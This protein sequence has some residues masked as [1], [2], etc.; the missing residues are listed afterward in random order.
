AVLE[1]LVTSVAR[2]CA[3]DRA[4]VQRVEGDKGVILAATNHDIRVG[5]FPI[6]G[7]VAEDVIVQMRTIHIFGTMD[8]Q[9]ARY[10]ASPAAGLGIGAQ[11][12]TP[13][14][15]EGRPIGVISL[16]R[17]EIRPFSDREIALLETFADQAV[18][19]IEN[20][21]LF[22]ALQEANQQFAEASQ[23]KSNFLANMSH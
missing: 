7:T 15:R 3:A 2:L 23:H 8:E 21:R 1:A 20:A 6:A 14:L 10:R 5:S 13:L 18:I 12:S 22:E 19:A 11:V 16:Q 9:L 17:T 4:N